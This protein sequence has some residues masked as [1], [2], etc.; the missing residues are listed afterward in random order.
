[1]DTRITVRPYSPT[2][3]YEMVSDW[4]AAHGHPV[5]DNHLLSPI[6]FVAGFN[7][8]DMVAV[9]LYFDRHVPVC[10]LGN[11]VSSPGL[12]AAEVADAGEAAIERCKDLARA[13]GTQQMRVYAP[14]A[15][16]RYARRGGFAIDASELVN[17][18]C[19]LKEEV[20]L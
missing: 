18:S 8:T 12:S 17:I 4:F 9:F 1:M 2:D 5:V 19:S 16:A 6:G 7:G 3:D 20:C 11:I 10:F 15:I 13:Y 14:K